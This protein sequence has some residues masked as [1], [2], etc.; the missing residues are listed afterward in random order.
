MAR[1][2]GVSQILNKQY[3]VLEM[4]DEWK[5]YIGTLPDPFSMIVIG[6]PK[7][8]KTS[9]VMRLCRHLAD[10]H[11]VFY[12]SLEEGDSKTI[13]DAL[14]LANMQDVVGSFFLGDGYTY[15]DLWE[16]LDKPRSPKIIVIDSL[17]YMKLTFEQWKKLN[18]KYPN[19][20]WIIICWGK[21]SSKEFA[22][23][24]DYF[25]RKIKYQVGTVV[26][27]QDFIVETRGRYGS[28]EKLVL[29]NK[30]SGGT[31]TKIFES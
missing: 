11:K 14:I 21:Y 7:N 13:Q 1:T 10:Y 9:F 17:D 31:Q 15:A 23:P 18:K 27:V 19:K 6:Q 30:K 26:R 20:S 8:G 3:K 2:L 22:I 25:G 5:N 16:K 28:T 4:S 12:S 24:D 29:W